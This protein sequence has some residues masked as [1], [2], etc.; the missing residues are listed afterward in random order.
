[1]LPA[2]RARPIIPID[3][4]AI[5]AGAPHRLVDVDA[6]P[7]VELDSNRQLEKSYDM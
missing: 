6:V 5:A 1:M 4:A 7:L 2:G 3:R